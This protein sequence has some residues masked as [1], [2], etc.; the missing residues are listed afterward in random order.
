MTMDPK[1][2]DRL[3]AMITDC[4]KTSRAS[5][6]DLS[7]IREKKM[8]TSHEGQC[9]MECVFS[10]TKIMNNGNF[11]KDSALKVIQK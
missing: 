5:E 9:L 2:K 11:D 8:P 7:A 6:A 10:A 4:Q 1:L 3:T